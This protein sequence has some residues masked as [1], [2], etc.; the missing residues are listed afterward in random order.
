MNLKF[1]SAL[2]AASALLAGPASAQQFFRIGTGGT[3]G[4]YYPIGGMI[5]NAVSQPGKI[6]ATAQ[7]T[8]G[9]LGNVNGIVGGA[10]E[11]GF[12]QS[13]VATWAQKG[14]GIFEGKPNV[15]GLRM[16]ANLY[17]E[18]LHI[19]VKKGSGYKSVADLKV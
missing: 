8:S 13:D 2:V 3:A 1:F 16:I 19:V 10:M 15:P 5:A 6:V 11:S 9:S 17:P 14:T 4:T 7:A 12:S 18:S